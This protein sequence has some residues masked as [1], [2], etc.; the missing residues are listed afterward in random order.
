[1]INVTFSQPNFRQAVERV[2]N[3]GMREYATRMQRLLDQLGRTSAGK[4]VE[5]V[6]VALQAAWRR[7]FEKTITDPHLTAWAQGLADGRRIV[8]RH[9]QVRL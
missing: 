7:A 6:K 4:P 2:A 5:E 8:V 3:E 9:Q 1:M